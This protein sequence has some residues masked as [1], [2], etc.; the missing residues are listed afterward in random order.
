MTA[1][2]LH[3]SLL[4]SLDG[5]D[6]APGDFLF[7]AR[8][9]EPIELTIWHP[10]P[11]RQ[12]ALDTAALAHRLILLANGSL[13][14]ASPAALLH[15]AI[16]GGGD[17]RNLE[18][19]WQDDGGEPRTWL[20]STM[21]QQPSRDQLPVIAGLVRDVSHA[22]AFIDTIAQ[23]TVLTPGHV[24]RNELLSS[25]MAT[26]MRQQ[27]HLISSICDLLGEQSPPAHG[28]AGCRRGDYVSDV[29]ATVQELIES[30]DLLR[31]YAQA[32]HG[33]LRLEPQRWQAGDIVARTLPGMKRLLQRHSIGLT[34]DG[35]GNGAIILADLP[36]LS[37]LL[38]LLAAAIVPAIMPGAW[39][40]L[41]CTTGPQGGIIFS[42]IYEGT[43]LSEA[44]LAS[45]SGNGSNTM[46]EADGI[47]RGSP[48]LA[49]P[50]LSAPFRKNMLHAHA[51]TLRQQGKAAGQIQAVFL[52][53]H[54]I[55]E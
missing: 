1:D 45:A 12:R 55:R 50:A 4:L 28:N 38:N 40:D 33:C 41:R 46:V 11:Q 23:A 30:A 24:A 15:R 49:H 37:R 27:A 18:L 32:E 6:A 29:R 48:D 25:S 13:P 44:Q 10:D 51:A 16:S 19:S 42:F 20:V 21:R 22:R 52:H 53:L 8:P 36:R 54:D 47:T 7:T 5:D 43:S 35:S 14:L 26:S 9:V 31:D 34:H 2:L 39:M 3:S 17:V